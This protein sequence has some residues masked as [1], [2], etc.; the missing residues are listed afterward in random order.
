[1][2]R[3]RL[4][5]R[6]RCGI[7]IFVELQLL[8]KPGL[9]LRVQNQTLSLTPGH[10]TDIVT[11]EYLRTGA[12]TTFQVGGPIPWSRVLLL[13]YRKK[14][15]R[16]TQFGAVGYI[17]ILYSSKNYVKSWEA[18]QILGRSGQPD[19]PVVAPMQTRNV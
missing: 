6:Q 17:I 15:D 5:D 7:H 13:F 8:Q 4:T 18:V 9:R 10:N 12:T 11:I 16:S 14:L 19:P 1:M 2:N 3:R